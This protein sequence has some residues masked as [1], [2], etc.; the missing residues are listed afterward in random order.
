MPLF[1]LLM[2]RAAGGPGEL[3]AAVGVVGLDLLLRA[4]EVAVGRMTWTEQDRN[5]LVIYRAVKIRSFMLLANGYYKNFRVK[6]KIQSS[7]RSKL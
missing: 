5:R 6:Y 4:L 1:L 2:L 3:S 7:L